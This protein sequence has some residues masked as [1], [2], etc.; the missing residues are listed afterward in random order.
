ML[1]SSNNR[2]DVEE[3]LSQA[4]SLLRDVIAFV[5]LFLTDETV[6]DALV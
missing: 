5:G 6:S 2:E 4:K 3:A 1:C